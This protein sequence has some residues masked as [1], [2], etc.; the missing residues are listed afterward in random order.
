[1]ITIW[2]PFEY[3]HILSIR[4]CNQGSKR[5][6]IQLHKVKTHI[7]VKMLEFNKKRNRLQGV[8]FHNDV[9]TPIP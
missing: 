6:W 5:F 1:M 3:G 8:S 2:I 9:S 7:R 4:H